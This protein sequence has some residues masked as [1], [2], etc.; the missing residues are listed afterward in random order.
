MPLEPN[1]EIDWCRISVLLFQYLFCL[2]FIFSSCPN[3]IHQLI[4]I[5]WSLSQHEWNGEGKRKLIL[6][7]L[8]TLNWF[9]CYHRRRF[10]ISLFLFTFILATKLHVYILKFVLFTLEWLD[11]CSPQ[12]GHVLILAFTKRPSRWV[13]WSRRFVPSHVTNWCWD[14]VPTWVNHMWPQADGQ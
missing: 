10:P 12:V 6:N 5:N 11:L 13:A 2:L 14:V 9:F 3:R 1:S 8:L 4:S 7:D